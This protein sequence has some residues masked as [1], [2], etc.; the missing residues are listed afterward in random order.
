[1]GIGTT[2]IAYKKGL[3]CNGVWVFIIS[4]VHPETPKI[5][6]TL[7]LWTPN[8]G[9]LGIQSCCEGSVSGWTLSNYL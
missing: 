6:P 2:K 1:M 7:A 4:N 3:D 9:Y 8:N 5:F